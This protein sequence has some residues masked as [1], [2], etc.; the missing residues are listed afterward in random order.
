MEQRH[1]SA[2]PPYD[3][4]QYDV[5]SVMIYRDNEEQ[6]RSQHI[7]PPILP[8]PPPPPYSHLAPPTRQ[9]MNEDSKR[10]E[11]FKHER[12][13]RMLVAGQEREHYNHRWP[14]CLMDQMISGSHMF[15]PSLMP[16]ELLEDENNM[17]Q[18]LQ[19]L[20]ILQATNHVTHMS[21]DLMSYVIYNIDT[22]IILD[23]SGSM[24]LDMMGANITQSSMYYTNSAYN[25][26]NQ[27]QLTTGFFSPAFRYNPNAYNYRMG[28][29]INDTTQQHLNPQDPRQSR[30]YHAYYT[31]TQWKQVFD[32]LGVHVRII[33][34]NPIN[35]RYEFA[36]SEL[37][38]IFTHQPHGSTPM[39]EAIAHAVT[40]IR[41]STSAY[42]RNQTT[43]CLPY[44]S[45]SNTPVPPH[46]A[47]RDRH[48]QILMVTDGEAN[49]M[50]SFNQI[51][52][53]TQNNYY[54]DV[55]L[56]I[57]ALSLQSR[58]VEFMDNEECEH[59]RVRAI[60]AFEIEEFQ[61]RNKLVAYKEGAYNYPMHIMRALLTNNYPCDYDFEAPLQTLRHR[62]YITMHSNDR[63]YSQQSAVYGIM[64]CL[65][66]I[67][68]TSPLYVATGCCCCGY[69]QGQDCGV[70]R[71]T[72][73]VEQFSGGD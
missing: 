53:A 68:C 2:P 71:P 38:L 18:R 58:D 22:C 12:K 13:K 20:P 67:V 19:S 6:Y 63:W 72:E 50:Q 45:C 48:L 60:E 26:I 21:Y 17:L 46:T 64:S 11:L 65:A 31:L 59:I 33:T 37:E 3:I 61:I 16:G 57:L 24:S 9:Q 55:Q 28:F 44:G 70:P 8:V 25:P 41:P 36:L 35:G 49:N 5:G 51:L 66:G 4:H 56:C 42:Q 14:H 32:I 15:P 39:T 34:C 10:I 73:C 29:N 23:N 27:V 40:G 43:D 54:G 47:T 69:L 62:L 52:D 1:D 7:V 30:W